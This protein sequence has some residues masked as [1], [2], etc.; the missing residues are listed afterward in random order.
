MTGLQAL[1][2]PVRVDPSDARAAA[3]VLVVA[4]A[5]LALSPVH[6]PL[7]CPLR[8]ATGVPCPLCGMTTS[9]VETLRL[10]V[11][12]A[13]AASPAGVGAVAAAAAVLAL[14]PRQ[15]RFP[16]GVLYAALAAMWLFQLHRFGFL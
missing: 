10:D 9:V 2:E 6:P 3:G 16:A 8:A 4:G 5:L 11:G 13:L 7:A 1:A 14:R 15:L 12:D